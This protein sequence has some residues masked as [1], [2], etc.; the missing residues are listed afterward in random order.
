MASQATI[1]GKIVLDGES[2]YKAALKSIRAEQREL[3]SEMTLSKASFE[4][5]QNSL[6]ALEQKYGILTKQID[7]QKEKIE[8]YQQAITG[9]GKEQQKAAEKVDILKEELHAAELQMESMKTGSEENADAIKD[10]AKV[11]ENLK[12]KL[13]LAEEGYDKAAGKVTYY[14]TEVNNAQ[15]ELA[16]MERELS[17]TGKYMEEAVAST[18]HCTKSIDEYGNEV[19]EATEDTSTFGD[20]LKANLLSDAISAGLKKLAEGIRAIA[21]ASVDVGSSFEASMSQV[22]ATMGMTVE[23]IHGG[24]RAYS[25]LEDAAK[26]AGK[27]TMYSASEAGEALNYLALAGYDA[28]KAAKTLPKT[29]QLAAAGG[30]DLGYATDLVTDSMAALN[31]ETDQL[32]TYMDQM[33]RTSQKSNTSIAQ[34]GEAT[35]V[36]AGAVSLSGQSLET[37]NTELGIL[38]NNGIKGAE[39]GTQLRNI[40]LSLSAPTDKAAAVIQK[41]GLEISD[42]QGN[43]RDLNAIMTD[44]NRAMD[45]MSSTER[46]QL[47]NKIFNRR[48]I[49][50]VNALLKGTGEEFDNLYQEISDSAGAA[51]NMADTLND[52]LKGKVTILQSALESLGISAYE[53]F[54]DSMKE[55]VD[56]A[57]GAVGRLQKSIDSGDLGVSLNRLSRSMAGFV[58]GA[59]DAG[60]EALPVL[61]DG[62]GW[63][64]DHADLLV[65]GIAGITAAHLEMSVVAPMIQGITAAW[66]TYK[67][68]NESAAVSQ[69]LLNVAMDANPAGLLI[70]AVT[71]LTAAVAAYAIINKD[72]YKTTDEVTRATYEQID[73]S[74]SLNEELAGMA[75]NR[76]ADREGMEA[77]AANCRNLVAELKELQ[78]KTSLT[79]G[80]QARMRMVVEELNQAL[81]GLN[82]QIDEQTNLLNMSTD[83]LEENVE[84]MMALSRAEAAREDL[85]KI[86]EEQY[87]AEKQLLEL[88]E[89]LA[90]QTIKAA[91]G[92]AAFGEA[93]ARE[94]RLAADEAAFII[95]ESIW[96][97][98]ALEEQ[99]RA[100]TDSMDALA[101]EYEWTMDYMASNEGIVASA[102]EGMDALGTAADAAGGSLEG[103]AEDAQAAQDALTEMYDSVEE[104]VTKQISLFTEFDGKAKLSTEELLRNMQTQV[105]GIQQWSENM[106]TLAERGISQG[107][108]KHLADLGPEGAGYVS[109][110]VNMTGEELQRANDLFNQSL[111]LPDET[112]EKVAEAYMLA[113]EKTA[114]GYGR[115]IRENTE[116]TVEAG[117]DMAEETFEAT[118]EVLNDETGEKVGTDYSSGIQK[119]ITESTESIVKTGKTMAEGTI[120]ATREV[121]N[122]GTG[123]GI[124]TDYSSGLRDGISRGTA[125]IAEA[126]KAMAV[127][128]LEGTRGVLNADAG[129]GIG[130]AYT[131]GIQGG[132]SAGQQGLV[133]ISRAVAGAVMVTF[134][135]GLAAD[136]AASI[137]SQVGAGLAQGI[138]DGKSSVTSAAEEICSAAVSAAMKALQINSPSK[139]F[140]YLG[141]MSG[142]GYKIG[143][144]DSMGDVDRVIASAMPE[145]VMNPSPGSA[146]GDAGGMWQNG[147]GTAGN[148]YEINQ[149]INIYGPVDDPIETARLVKKANREAAE[150]W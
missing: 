114:Q 46:V 72:S 9:W 143:W 26:E 149:E 83:V 112:A 128:T 34:L 130:A 91:A 109:A 38:A 80:E 144:Q 11:I 17:Q 135:D 62:L 99:I 63:I 5:Q 67:T 103:M 65:A 39:G 69:W 12:D 115:G 145:A 73:A 127:E 66:R 84:A 15:A 40:I 129:E 23:E 139:K 1:G 8:V 50:A 31:L 131:S 121:L 102:A 132:I 51:K 89:Q 119:G 45:G 146:S 106:A 104:M 10:Q 58:E 108:L 70:G 35:L 7:K 76:A 13:A 111:L 59:M 124:G 105:D 85:G 57:T 87:E 148:R 71:A 117:A 88:R 92:A 42:S 78:S 140:R 25:M 28:E 77:E 4:G 56:S 82:L 68:A 142:E 22:A 60:E 138:R 150:D 6:E 32:E 141:E 19:G 55:A 93:E 94:R 64:L 113:G 37:M 134:Q 48:D 120:V 122:A 16:G 74:K 101:D 137:G 18:N 96:A 20:V 49:A 116:G 29:L 52:N 33:A 53:I 81:P 136:K 75:E 30:L 14:Q 133:N 54:D 100:T 2:E 61:I 126:G 79:S 110:F 98:E 44:L 125:G 3:R 107:L 24:S 47:I 41:L 147:E 86:A 90:A 123:E 95:H 21:V 118:R 43:M 27:T 36:C 97:K